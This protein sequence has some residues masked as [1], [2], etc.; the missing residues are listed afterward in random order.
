MITYFILLIAIGSVFFIPKKYFEK[1]GVFFIVF[2]FAILFATRNN[3]AIDDVS[4]IKIFNRFSKT[5][6]EMTTHYP[7]VEIPLKLIC[8]FLGLL[9]FNYKG[10]FLVYA[11]LSYL[12][13]G[14]FLHK[15]KLTKAETFLF[16]ITFFAMA[17]F[18]YMTTMRQFLA[19]TIALYGLALLNEKKYGQ[20][21]AFMLIAVFYHNSTIV[22][23]LLA[24][25][26]FNKVKINDKV[27]IL[28]PLVMLILGQSGVL[29]QI[30][31]WVFSLFKNIKYE[32]YV[33]NESTQIYHGSGL[34]HYLL[35]IVYVIQCFLNKNKEEN[36]F[37]T[38]GI[39]LYFVLFYMT[40]NSG[41]AIRVSYL[42]LVFLCFL[43][44]LFLRQIEPIKNK[45]IAF[46]VS[47]FILVILTS[48]TFFSLQGTNFMKND[49]SIDYFNTEK[50]AN[51]EEKKIE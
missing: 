31:V 37:L 29:N 25:V 22:M 47:C 32:A 14:L 10:L 39:M 26:F 21:I 34:T 20:A 5:L 13:L 9:H 24:P 46:Y 42:Y 36:A 1:Y 48:K 12:F 18:T 23:L 51:I 7:N 11:L 19:I 33:I 43:F 40:V 28:L 8:A 44:I 4:Y 45:K 17:F 2:L 41:F 16:T 35:F 49:F 27:K 50:I 38:K 30:L 15:M 3:V 6:E